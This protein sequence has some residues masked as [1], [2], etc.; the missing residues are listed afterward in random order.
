MIPDN[1]T[2]MS[3][4][5]ISHQ[6]LTVTIH[7]PTEAPGQG[8]STTLESTTTDAE[9][10]RT[11]TSTAATAASTEPT[12]HGRNFPAPHYHLP[13]SRWGPFFEEGPEPHNITAR[14]GSTVMLDCRI[15]LLQ[16]KMVSGSFVNEKLF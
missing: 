2:A 15:G 12:K 6:P 3:N 4:D 1:E 8:S 10:T 5:I 9:T 11:H 14:V 13:D 16:D 7:P